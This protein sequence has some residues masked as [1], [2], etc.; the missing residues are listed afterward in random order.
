MNSE[1]VGDPK[2]ANETRT[3]S[4]QA[5]VAV[6]L[7][8][9]LVFASLRLWVR[10]KIIRGFGKDDWAMVAAIFLLIFSGVLCVI[11]STL[12]LGRHM[13]S[14][15][16]GEK[17]F[18]LVLIWVASVGYLATVIV[19]K[20]AFLLQ[21]RRVFPLPRFQRLCDLFLWFLAIWFLTG[22]IT[23]FSLCQ[24]VK[25]QWSPE[26]A[27]SGKSCRARYDFWLANGIIHVV[28]DIVLFLMPLPMIKRLPLDKTHKIALGGVFSLGFFICA[29][30]VIRLKTLYGALLGRDPSWGMSTTLFW[31]VGEATCA[32]LCLCIPT[33]RPLL[34]RRQ[35]ETI[36]SDGQGSNPW[37]VPV[38]ELENGSY[39]AALRDT[40]G[41]SSTTAQ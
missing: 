10:L 37:I 15:L 40:R 21:Y 27:Q 9:S 18:I 31:S 35:Q 14:L 41:F 4:V 20:S 25:N 28:T 30:S 13:S 39:H 8:V 23:H 1:V 22:F 7:V 32:F 34:G 5:F 16:H 19:L 17:I 26:V 38:V 36:S 24:P 29:I 3:A 11:A 2:A 6:C 12:G 33:L